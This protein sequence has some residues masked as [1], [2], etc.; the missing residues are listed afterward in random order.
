MRAFIL[1]ASAIAQCPRHSLVADHYYEDGT[2]RCA[3]DRRPAPTADTRHPAER[4]LQRPR[5]RPTGR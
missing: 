2:C 3:D 5:Q 1:K 4:R